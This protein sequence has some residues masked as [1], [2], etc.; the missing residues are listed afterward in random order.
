M[1]VL[2]DG[3]NV[4]GSRADGWW[5]D[6]RG[7]MRSLASALERY[8]EATGEE[9]TLVLDGRPFDLG[10]LERVN[11]V[12]APGPGPN[13]ADRVIER[14]VSEDEDPSAITVVTSDAA[15]A[16][17]VRAAGARVKGAGGF[18][19]RLDELTVS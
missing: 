5:R 14:L 12:F 9:V 13:A 11:A 2:V 15:L 3:M 6:R 4:I 1:R 8:A 18:R 19:R 10:R 16:A 7:A 17:A